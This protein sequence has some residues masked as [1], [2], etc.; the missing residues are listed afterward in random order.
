MK[1]ID[2]AQQMISD[3]AQVRQDFMV[4]HGKGHARDKLV[5]QQP[6]KRRMLTHSELTDLYAN[7][8]LV[9]NIIDIPPEDMVRAGWNIKTENI[10]LKAAIESKLRKL[11]A[12]DAFKKM[13]SYDRLYGDG[14]ISLGIVQSNRHQLSSAIILD[15]LKRIPYL[16]TFSHQMLNNIRVNED[17]FS[18]RYGMAEYFSVNRRKSSGTEIIHSV[19][20][21]QELVHHSRIIHQQSKRFESEHEGVS[22]IN[23][24][25]D[26]ITVMDTTLWS[27]GQMM[28]DF[29]FKVYKAEG[30][31]SI[32][33]EDR[34]EL[35]M[36]MDFM[37]RTEALAIIGKDEELHK[38][39]TSV[40]GIGALLDYGW[41]Y[42]AGAT[43][44]P[45][46]ILKGQESGTISGAEFDVM[47]YYARISSMQENYLRPHLEYLIRLL[48]W[49]EDECGG[50]VDPDTIEWSIEFNPLWNTDVET[51]AK[52]RK[53]TAEA[54]A[55]NIQN[56][57]LDPDAV[58]QARFGRFGLTNS[59]KYNADSADDYKEMAK[60]VYEA[61][62]HDRSKK[63]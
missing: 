11:K 62:E 35:S 34:Q 38:E 47:N 25:Y 54:D 61:F 19:E 59:S 56:G 31:D 29:A 26:I 18:E 1:T 17:V 42:L 36:L 45:K 58:Y 5:R 9:Q 60:K 37:F 21:T 52:I 43:R 23:A 15:R 7:N 57:V 55:I 49:A 27:V 50:R 46:S 16:N 33:K 53:L 3:G 39:A 13:F 4:G 30:A 2:R 24:M 14:F 8:V 63:S 20:Q 6:S 48:M 40:S 51:D 22:I 41:D 10:E 32:N 44:M 12:K 28:H